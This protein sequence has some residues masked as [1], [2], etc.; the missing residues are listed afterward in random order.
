MY[1]RFARPVLRSTP[2]CRAS[3]A[4]LALQNGLLG[5]R[6][7]VSGF[8]DRSSGTEEVTTIGNAVHLQKLI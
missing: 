6:G 3:V 7:Q 4:K 5:F 1:T 2:P 8:R